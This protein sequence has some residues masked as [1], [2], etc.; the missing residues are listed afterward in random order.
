MDTQTVDTDEKI[1]LISDGNLHTF[2]ENAQSLLGAG[3]TRCKAKLIDPESRKVF[4][5]S[6]IVNGDPKPKQLIVCQLS[7]TKDGMRIIDKAELGKVFGGT[8]IIPDE[9]M[10]TQA[11]PPPF[12]ST[13]DKNE[14]ARIDLANQQKCAAFLMSVF[15]KNR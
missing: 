15:A 7:N 11:A 2:P 12:L 5:V 8:K 14:L 1:F 4:A 13:E 3:V 9:A 10:L 6:A